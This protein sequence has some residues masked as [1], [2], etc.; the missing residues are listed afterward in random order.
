[1]PNFRRAGDYEAFFRYG[2]GDQICQHYQDD[3]KHGG[4]KA[5]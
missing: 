4:Q 1:M 5:L 3:G 2:G